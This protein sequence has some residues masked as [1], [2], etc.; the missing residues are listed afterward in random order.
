[1]RV[2]RKKGEKFET[3]SPQTPNREMPICLVEKRMIPMMTKMTMQITWTIHFC[4]C[5]PIY[6]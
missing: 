3:L 2:V 1:M 6:I 4:F 5:Q